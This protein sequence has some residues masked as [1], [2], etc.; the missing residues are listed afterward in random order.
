MQPTSFLSLEVGRWGLSSDLDCPA[1]LLCDCPGRAG[2]SVWLT[3][4]FSWFPSFLPSSAQGIARGTWVAAWLQWCC[5]CE[6]SVRVR[7]VGCG[8]GEA[9]PVG[10]DGSQNQL[11]GVEAPIE[12]TICACVSFQRRI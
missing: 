5:V 4:R 7:A 3:L 6:V 8:P 9:Q 11:G 12:L 1:H 2:F 10:R